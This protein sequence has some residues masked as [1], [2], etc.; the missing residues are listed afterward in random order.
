VVRDELG[1]PL[2]AIH[3]WGSPNYA[4]DT[5]HPAVLAWLEHVMRTVG[6]DWGFA[7][8]KLDFLYAAA[9]RG[10]RVDRDATGVEAYRR[11]LEQL[12]RA[13]GD[14]FLLGC[15]APLV[16]SIGLV[17]G[18][19]I[20]ADVAAYWGEEGN[21]DGPSLRNATRATLARLWMHG[22]W[23]T[24]DPD[25]VVVR[26]SH[27][28]L[29]LAE[30]QAWLSVVALSGGMVL[31]GDD[32][33]QVE[34]QRLELLGRLLP[35]SGVAAGAYPPLAALMPQRVHLR[36]DRSHVVAIANWDDG[37]AEAVWDPRDFPDLDG[38]A[39]YHLVD[40]WSGAY[41]G[42]HPGPLALGRLP[43]HGVRLLAVHA[44]LGRPQVIGS[45]G[46]LLGDV[47]DLASERWNPAA[48]ELTIVPSGRGPRS[49]RGEFVVYAPNGPPRRVPFATVDPRPIRLTY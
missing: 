8:V 24:N 14:R 29:S 20:G 19:R 39:R 4:I 9:M 31:V 2:N 30:V 43:A 34:P 13:A 47:M 6:G 25:C 10:R 17:D 28:Q 36:A 27:T 32:V 40:L 12:R 35:P 15:G 22:R 11:G 3:N 23:W 5:T 48:Q 45:T 49:R 38:A 41:L 21:P 33:S 46:H 1:E 44:D 37:E 26:A 18:M 42:A 7:Y 16:P